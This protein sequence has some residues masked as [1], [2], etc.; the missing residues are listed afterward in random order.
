MA[1]NVSGWGSLT[2]LEEKRIPDDVQA[3]L[4]QEH[5]LEEARLEAAMKAAK[6]RGWC[7]DLCPARRTGNGDGTTG[8][9]GLLARA[10]VAFRRLQVDR[11]GI[12]APGTARQ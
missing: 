6:A 8:G 7:A 11:D 1:A 10:H 12:H 5:H 9:V 3:V 4:I 2:Q